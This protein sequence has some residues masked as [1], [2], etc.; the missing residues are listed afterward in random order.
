VLDEND[1]LHEEIKILHSNQARLEN[2]LQA[3]EADC[4]FARQHITDLQAE[5]NARK[6]DSN[7]KAEW[8]TSETNRA[9]KAEEKAEEKVVEEQKEAGVRKR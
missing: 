9:R 8:L 5:H 6:K 4:L 1:H 7:T 2:L 3:G